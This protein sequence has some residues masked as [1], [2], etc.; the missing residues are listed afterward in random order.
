MAT[1]EDLDGWLEIVLKYKKIETTEGKVVGY[2]KGTGR[3]ASFVGSM[4]LV[5]RDGREFKCVPPDRMNPPP[6]G[7]IV[8]VECLELTINGLPR[9]PR[10]KGLRTDLTW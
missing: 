5:N 7:S 2:T 8:E 10:W 6:V 3:F 1:R 4:R 9:H